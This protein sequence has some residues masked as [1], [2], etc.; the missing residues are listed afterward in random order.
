MQLEEELGV[1]LFRRS[2]HRIILTD[3]G[4]LLRRRAQEIVGLAEGRA[5]AASGGRGP[6]EISIGSGDLKSISLLADMLAEFHSGVSPGA[7]CDLQREFGRYQGA[8]RTG[9]SGYRAAA[10]A[11]GDQ[12]I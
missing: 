11:G 12:Q 9:A 3:A 7:V 1:K 8:Y 6:G 10:G 2:Q 5:G 4:V